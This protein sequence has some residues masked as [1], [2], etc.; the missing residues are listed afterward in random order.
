MFNTSYL[1]E[2]LGK[3]GELPESIQ[4]KIGG[5]AAVAKLQAIE[6]KYHL[7]LSL[8]VLL[9][10]VGEITTDDLPEYLRLE[11]SISQEIS[12]AIADEIEDNIFA[13]IVDELIKAL[14][15]TDTAAAEAPS[16][17]KTL[18]DWPFDKKRELILNIFSKTI[19]PTLKA[20]NDYLR[21]L[22]I[23]I[24]QV[25]NADEDFEEKIISLLYNNSEILTRSQINLDNHSS[26]PTV[27]NWL[28]DF[29]S[30]YGSDLFSEVDLAEYLSSGFNVGPLS[31][32][33]KDLVKKLLK[34][35][36][37]LVFFPESVENVPVKDWSVFPLDEGIGAVND[38]LDDQH[39]AAADNPVLELDD[40]QKAIFD[41][42]KNLAKYNPASLEYKAIK[43]EISRLRK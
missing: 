6:D 15:Q 12:E 14:A 18:V 3:F 27:A 1:A 21:Q 39:P 7:E 16:Q 28:K 17:E 4:E 23:A 41:L 5:L 26:S 9:V 42:E 34:L 38:V 8:A 22:N 11:F 36:R 24:F 30:Q 37:N 2:C 31:V 43:Q 33:E 32:G 40:K 13:P 25:L 19:V 10:A 29:I 35:Y 20:D